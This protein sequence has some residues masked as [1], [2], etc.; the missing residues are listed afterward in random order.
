MALAQTEAPPSIP[1]EEE[2]RR[3]RWRLVAVL[4]AHR[5]WLVLVIVVASLGQM[6]V[7][8][9]TAAR[10]Q[11]PVN[12]EPAYIAAAASYVHHHSLRLN[13][14]H[15][16]L[17]KLVSGVGIALAD[18]RLGR[19]DEGSQWQVGRRV[20]YEWGND[21]DRILWYARLPLIGLTLL[22]GL[23]VFAFGR[24]LFGPVGGV[25]ALC[26]YAFSPDVIAHGSLATNDVPLAGF[27]VTTFWLL[28]R[29]RERPRLYLPLA[30]A[31]FGCAVGT[32]M[33]AL[34][35][36]PVVFLLAAAAVWRTVQSRRFM[37]SVA[38][39]AGVCLISVVTVWLMY[40]AVDP[41]LRF[42]PSS[43]AAQL[44]GLPGLAFDLLPL[45]ASFRDGLLVQVGFETRTFNGFL[46]GEH[47]TGRRWYYL[48]AALLVKTP[49]GAMA[50]WLAAAAALLSVRR[51]RP[52]ALYLLV[53]PAV[54]LAIAMAGS[55]SLG[56]RYAVWLPIFLAVAA[57]AALSLYRRRW[58][59]PVTVALVGLVAVSSLRTFPYYI[60]Y[61]NEAFGGPDE[62]Y[63]HLNDSNVD[64]GQDMR[65]LGRYLDEHHPGE[66]VWL[67][68]KGRGDPEYY[69][70]DAADPTK[71]PPDQ[72]RGILAVSVM[73]LTGSPSG[74][75]ELIGDR[76]PITTIGHTVKVYRLS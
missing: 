55:R 25:L 31:A 23:V 71:V 73:R 66:R 69:G 6:L 60:P 22:F 33:T 65:R 18:V 56:T 9:L 27:L 46:F 38:V 24:D 17:A 3:G 50:L 28:W 5:R 32:K 2:P 75:R 49:L 48:P 40:L 12:D 67:I 43:N 57:P 44:S 15:P 35:M 47:Y 7:A 30:G 10:E 54:L 1:I 52:V 36:Y 16:P 63:L 53:P 26:L 13:P 39:A 8:M 34:P 41:R 64:W 74:Y 11:A 4:R 45:P 29:A 21:A 72:V 42:T 51:L 76:R 61:S 19:T 14:E 37:T 70:I 20:L 58:S 62:T 59:L 68:F